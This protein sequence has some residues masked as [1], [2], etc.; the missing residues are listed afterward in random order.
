[1]HE[2]SIASAVV[3]SVLEFVSAHSVKKVLAVRLAIGELSHIEA[4]Q[5]H[6]CYTAITEQTPIQDSTLEIETVKA[7]VRCERCS[8]HGR[9]KYWDDALSAGPILTLQ[10]PNCGATVE[11]IE[12]NDCVIKSIR[13][14]VEND[15]VTIPAA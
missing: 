9:P 5:L 15:G 2:L 6:F 7:V 3:E 1:M 12:G 11:A 14:A 10:C 13:F 4:D 8:Y